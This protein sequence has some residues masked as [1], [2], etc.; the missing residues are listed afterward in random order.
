M[1]TVDIYSEAAE[2]LGWPGSA[3][4]INYLKVLFTPEEGKLLLEFI[5]PATC[6]Q[7]AKKLGMDEKELQAKLDHFA[8]KRRLLF[9]GKTEYVFQLGLH[10]FF[11]AVIVS[12][13][14]DIPSGF[15][16][17][18]AEFHKE[19]MLLNLPER[20]RRTEADPAKVPGSRVVPDRLAIAASPRIKK[21]DVLWYEDM[22]QILAKEDVISL[23]PCGC[24]RE[25]HNCDKPIWTCFH[26]G[27]AEK[28]D[29]K[30]ENSVKKILTYEEAMETSDMCERAGLLHL[31]GNNIEIPKAV[32]CHCCDDCCS[33][34]TPILATGRLRQF[35]SP[36]RYLAVV[37]EEKCTGCQTCVERCY[38]NGVMMRPSVTSKKKKKAYV[39]SWNCMGCG[40]CILGCKQGAITFEL[41]R[42]PE[43]IPTQPPAQGSLKGVPGFN[44]IRQETLK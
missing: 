30:P 11:N 33:T 29:A 28:Q 12:K 25:F 41:V 23:A 2:K 42:P 44:Y 17:A 34:L 26:F 38:F 39:M 6:A 14:E 5:K 15:W 27:E 24:R 40:S 9:H 4:C 8:D 7:V 16:P 3:S 31:M 1:L 21:E 19:E 35:Y 20:I 22:A 13:E 37:D 36:S 10:G 18:Y 43:H 32:L